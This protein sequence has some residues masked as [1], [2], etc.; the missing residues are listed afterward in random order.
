MRIYNK[1][2]FALGICLV[3]LGAANLIL[4]IV[5]ASFDVKGVIIIA[6]LLLLGFGEIV[7]SLS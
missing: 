6:A 5:K 4:D 3:V 7:R 2:K 1:K